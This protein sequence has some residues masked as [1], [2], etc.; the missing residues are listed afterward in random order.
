MRV[1]R[2]LLGAVALLAMSSAATA[3]ETITYTYD[4]KGR[5]VKV[6]RTGTVNNNVTVEYTH[7]KADN[8][9]RLKTTNSPNPPP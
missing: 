3:A 6:V 2:V 5:L 9:T 1:G 4:A 8:R 7:D